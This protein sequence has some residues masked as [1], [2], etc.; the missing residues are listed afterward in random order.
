MLISFLALLI[1]VRTDSRDRSALQARGRCIRRPV[2]SITSNPTT[3]LIDERSR[4]SFP[5]FPR[6]GEVMM[7][8]P[9]VRSPL[10]FFAVRQSYPLTLTQSPHHTDS[11][12]YAHPKRPSSCRKFAMRKDG[13]GACA[14]PRAGRPR[15]RSTCSKSSRNSQSI[16]PSCYVLLL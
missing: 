12:F 11:A 8:T 5:C 7:I 10:P 6:R 4:T 3:S 15:I 14:L 2:L 13:A 9:A 1:S 16:H